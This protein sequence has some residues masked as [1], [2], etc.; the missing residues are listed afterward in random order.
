MTTV[1]ARM[2][3]SRTIISKAAT[4]SKTSE[5][6]HG[7]HVVVEA[8]HQEAVHQEVA[9]RIAVVHAGNPPNMSFSSERVSS[10]F[11]FV[12]IDSNNLPT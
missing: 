4:S 12:I 1:I 3:T 2:I 7:T 9:P 11:Y 6:E 5:V 10:L 8:A